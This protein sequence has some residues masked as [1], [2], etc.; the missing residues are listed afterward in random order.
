MYICVY[1]YIYIYIYT[2]PHV[3][4]LNVGHRGVDELVRAVAGV[5]AF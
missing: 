4:V 3:D 1:I 5:L 2:H